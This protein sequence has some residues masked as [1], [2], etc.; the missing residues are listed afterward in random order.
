M[1]LDMLSDYC[2]EDQGNLNP[3]GK[4]R[5]RTLLACI[6]LCVQWERKAVSTKFHGD[7]PGYRINEFPGK[8]IF[9]Q[10][11]YMYNFTSLP[12]SLP[13][14]T[15]FLNDKLG[16]KVS[17]MLLLEL[18]YAGTAGAKKLSNAG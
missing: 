3:Q 6:T 2:M 8:C 16:K 11:L 15:S 18:L 4:P 5:Q 12:P 14:M 7:F 9:I 17:E 1:A 13:L 10:Q